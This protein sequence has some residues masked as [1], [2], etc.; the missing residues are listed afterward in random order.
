[1][2]HGGELCLTNCSLNAQEQEKQHIELQQQHSEVLKFACQAGWLGFR[3]F[4][5]FGG[6]HGVKR[7]A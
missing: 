3:P 1:M 6:F 5:P 7:Q 2:V 4:R